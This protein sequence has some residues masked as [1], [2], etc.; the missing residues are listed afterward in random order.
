MAFS[1]T[2]KYVQGRQAYSYVSAANC[3]VR[4]TVPAFNTCLASTAEV[5]CSRMKN[6]R[7][8]LIAELN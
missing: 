8:H 6:E 7:T 2:V 5:M 1:A 4:L 3:F